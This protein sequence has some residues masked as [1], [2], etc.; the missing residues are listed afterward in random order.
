MLDMKESP[1]ID[2]KTFRFFD[3]TNLAL[4]RISDNLADFKSVEKRISN[5]EKNLRYG[6]GD[7]EQKFDIP[8]HNKP[9]IIPMKKSV[10]TKY[11]KGL[12]WD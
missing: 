7:S 5:L 3:E 6:S 12:G 8:E 2:V 1:S 10:M 9:G 4:E 11:E